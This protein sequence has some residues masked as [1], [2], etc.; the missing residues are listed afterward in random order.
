MPVR[1]R[2]RISTLPH[3][4]CTVQR[5]IGMDRALVVLTAD[6]GE[7]FG[8]HGG[9]YHAVALYDEVVHVAAN[10]RERGAAAAGGLDAGVAQLTS[11]RPCLI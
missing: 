8:E 7:E 1:S 6:H 3:S 5:V 4:S 10:D 11:R 9:Q 2:S